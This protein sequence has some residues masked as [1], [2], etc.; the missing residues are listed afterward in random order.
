MSF[1]KFAEQ[2]SNTV[3]I[4]DTKTAGT[5]IGSNFYGD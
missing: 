1:L 3:S 4:S 5:K 2:K